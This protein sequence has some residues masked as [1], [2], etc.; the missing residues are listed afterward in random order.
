MPV[1]FTL[2]T[3]GPIA[4]S[5]EDCAIVLEAIAGHDPRDPTTA[6]VPVPPYRRELERGADGLRVGVVTALIERADPRIGSTVRGAVE[7][8]AGGGR[9]RRGGRGTAPR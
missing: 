4:P 5:A 2:D 1:S 9:R 3:V 7:K 8:L 6:D